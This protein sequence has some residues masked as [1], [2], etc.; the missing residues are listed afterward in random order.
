MGRPSGQ[1]LLHLREAHAHRQGRRRRMARVMEH[2]MV[3]VG[4]AEGQTVHIHTQHRLSGRAVRHHIQASIGC[5]KRGRHLADRV[6]GA[7]ADVELHHVRSR[8]IQG[9]LRK[10]QRPRRLQQPV[11]H[12]VHVGLG[13]RLQQVGGRVHAIAGHREIGAHRHER[14]RTGV[15]VRPQPTRHRQAGRRFG[16]AR[17]PL[18]IGCWNGHRAIGG[19]AVGGHVQRRNG[20]RAVR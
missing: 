5:G 12:G 7:L 17:G 14:Y 16:R 6:R 18:T 15:A 3:T 8:M 4:A 11:Q 13:E 20:R 19:H 1:R 9:G 10:P 2:H